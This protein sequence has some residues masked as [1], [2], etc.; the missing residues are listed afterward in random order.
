MSGALSVHGE[1]FEHNNFPFGASAHVSVPRVLASSSELVAPLVVVW[2]LFPFHCLSC[3]GLG[4]F[5]IQI[6]WIS[7]LLA[8]SSFL[9]FANLMV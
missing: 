2:G 4:V 8:L 1:G 7:V 3:L 9:S 5:G 6:S